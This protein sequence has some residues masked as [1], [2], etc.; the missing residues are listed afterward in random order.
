MKIIYYL[1][2]N[3]IQRKIYNIKGNLWFA[4]YVYYLFFGLHDSVSGTERDKG[5]ITFAFACWED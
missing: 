2:E 4:L 5:I 3:K 1:Y